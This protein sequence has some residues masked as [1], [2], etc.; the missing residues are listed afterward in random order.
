MANQ[1]RDICKLDGHSLASVKTGEAVEPTFRLI[2]SQYSI[3]CTKC[4]QSLD[5]VRANLPT[6]LKGKQDDPQK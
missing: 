6:V 3:L 1:S 4:G 5:E 2:V